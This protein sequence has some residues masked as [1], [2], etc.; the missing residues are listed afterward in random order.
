MM[1][2]EIEDRLESGTRV[3]LIIILIAIILGFF[4]R[5]IPYTDY[6]SFRS[7]WEVG[8]TYPIL[9]ILKTGHMPIQSEIA[10]QTQ[11]E[12]AKY[13]S[14]DNPF[15]AYFASIILLV[16]GN[17][18][19]EGVMAYL[20]YGLFM[21]VLGYPIF[22]IL[23]AH[24]LSKG[25]RKK[26]SRTDLSLIYSLVTL[27]SW[28]LLQDTAIG[29][30]LVQFGLIHLIIIFYVLAESY[31]SI[32]FKILFFLF[33][34][35]L[36]GYYHTTSIALIF[37]L[38]PLLFFSYRKIKKLV[39]V[40]LFL[41]YI[42]AFLAYFMF[43][44]GL[45]FEYFVRT[46]T[47]LGLGAQRS[48]Q[49]YLLV[50]RT[51]IWWTALFIINVA[52]ITLPTLFFLGRFR[53]IEKK[54]GTVYNKT[55]L[56]WIFGIL[57]F[58]IILGL[59]GGSGQL[60]SRGYEYTSIIGILVTII[61][62]TQIDKHKRRKIL[63]LISLVG[64]M[65]ASFSFLTS[66]VAGASFPYRFAIKND[67]W[68][69]GIWASSNIPDQKIIFTDFRL[70]APIVLFG[71]A[72]VDGIVGDEG[73]L[74]RILLE[75]VYYHPEEE[76]NLVSIISFRRKPDFLLF[77]KEMN[78]MGVRT[79]SPTFEPPLVIFF[80]AYDSSPHFNRIYDNSDGVVYQITC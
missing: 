14:L 6:S 8:F 3:A 10:I 29:V 18:S 49:Q 71:N 70:I 79:M 35:S 16:T 60:L 1:H 73:E 50:E 12:E 55:I 15:S 51:S 23:I 2:W 64:I 9:H 38:L 74:T 42:I 32:N 52:T 34:F 11:F 27:G 62:V 46:A 7:G 28:V 17:T 53:V 33:V 41:F 43:L 30:N 80:A 66:S 19:T 58:A 4:V 13:A 56:Y 21:G 77:S 75:K 20:R 69:A 47:N 31:R 72:S 40:P 44:Y 24:R 25:A 57:C 67:E 45:S 68:Q 39:A 59:W 78:R 22:S 26:Y 54:Q 48:L 65:S 36:I 63:V 37:L 5:V 61:W 76:T